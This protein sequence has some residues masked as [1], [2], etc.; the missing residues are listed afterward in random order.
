MPACMRQDGER[1]RVAAWLHRADRLHRH[2][3]LVSAGVDV[4]AMEIYF[5]VEHALLPRRPRE[6]ASAA[7]R[8]ADMWQSWP[9]ESHLT[10]P[11]VCLHGDRKSVVSG[12]RL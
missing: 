11:L 4:A 12:K 5:A 8:A 10:F 7:G 3:E 6:G 1:F 9:F 2:Y